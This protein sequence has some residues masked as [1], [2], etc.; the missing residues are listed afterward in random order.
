MNNVK[1]FE[2]FFGACICKSD[3]MLFI[4]ME[5]GFLYSA[6]EALSITQF[7]SEPQV[8]HYYFIFCLRAL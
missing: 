5:E 7:I 2:S 8:T 1:Q 6:M 3:F 4:V